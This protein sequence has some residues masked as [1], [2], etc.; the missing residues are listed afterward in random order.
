M[1]VVGFNDWGLFFFMLCWG[2]FF[3]VGE[4]MLNVVFDVYYD[5]LLECFG[6]NSNVVLND[7]D[8]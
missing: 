7:F 1:S 5:L 6:N 8:F 4:S 2:Y 3:L